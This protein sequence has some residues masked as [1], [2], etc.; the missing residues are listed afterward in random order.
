MINNTQTFADAFESMS[1][2]QQKIYSEC[3]SDKSKRSFLD[4]EQ[5]QRE[6]RLQAELQSLIATIRIIQ[7]KDYLEWYGFDDTENERIR[8]G[9]FQDFDGVRDTK[10]AVLGYLDEYHPSDE[11][12]LYTAIEELPD[13][14]WIEMQ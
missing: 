13:G 4:V 7:L 6:T 1:P 3:K 10:D 12:K 2:T 11:L 9:V 14:V 8:N 5:E